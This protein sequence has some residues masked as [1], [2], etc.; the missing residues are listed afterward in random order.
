MLGRTDAELRPADEAAA[1][2]RNDLAVM[3]AGRAIEI[4]EVLELP[5]G[6]HTFLTVKFPLRDDAGEIYAI[7]G[8]STDITPRKRLEHELRVQYDKLKQLDALKN[9]FVNAVSHDLRTPLTSIRG[10]SEFL[11]DEI[12][13]A[14]S[15]DQ[16]GFVSQIQFSTRRLETLVDDL[17]DAARIEA[18]TFKLRVATKVLRDP[19]R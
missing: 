5:D 17:L 9:E 15:P 10:Y 2:R 4:E 12:G 3:E 18:G 14:L 13:G 1:F 19:V 8:I 6:P 7:G 11:E 16:H